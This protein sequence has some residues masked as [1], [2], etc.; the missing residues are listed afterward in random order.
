MK[1]LVC[2]GKAALGSSLAVLRLPRNTLIILFVE[3]KSGKEQGVSLTSL[4]YLAQGLSY[5]KVKLRPTSLSKRR[6][7][8]ELDMTWDAVRGHRQLDWALDIVGTGDNNRIEE[9]MLCTPQGEVVMPFYEPR[10]AFQFKRG[11]LDM[12]SNGRIIQAQIIGR[13]ENRETGVCTACIWDVRGHDEKVESG[14]LLP[15]KKHLYLDFVTTIHNFGAWH[16][17]IVPVGAMSRE[18]IGV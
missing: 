13:V 17:D 15:Q 6:E 4:I 3:L 9:L 5:W 14:V 7:F 11:T 1:L 8:S 10:T 12:L 18:V 2:N 16:T